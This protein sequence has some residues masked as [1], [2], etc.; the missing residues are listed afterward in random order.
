MS[1]GR[2]QQHKRK[3]NL[4]EDKIYKT[5]IKKFQNSRSILTSAKF[6]QKFLPKYDKTEI[7]LLHLRSKVTLIK[8]KEG[9][10]F[11]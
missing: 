5:K 10:S 1:K 3:N 9:L 7:Q 11:P 8:K 6:N 4:R 2:P